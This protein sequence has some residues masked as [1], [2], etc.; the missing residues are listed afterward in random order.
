[1]TLRESSR[2]LIVPFLSLC[3]FRGG[4][5]RSRRRS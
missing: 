1:M 2:V 3:G 4:S 5:T